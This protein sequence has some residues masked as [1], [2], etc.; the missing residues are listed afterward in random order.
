MKKH[1][2]T[3]LLL[4][5]C[6]SAYTQDLSFF[7]PKGDFSYDQNIPTPNQFFGHEIGAQHV[8]YD[9]AVAYMKLLAQK[10]DRIS[11]E[12]RGRTYQYRPIL[13]LYISSPDN[14]DNLENIRQDHLK[15]CDPA[16]SDK[17]D[18]QEMPIV[19]WLGYSIHGNEASGINA[20]LVVAYFLAAAQGQE[21]DRILRNSVIIMQPGT[22]PDGI[23]R[24]TTW[25]NNARSFT[26]VKDPNS[27]EFREPAPGS[28]GNHY[29]FD[30]NR[31]WVMVQQ[32]ESF[33]RSQ[34][35]YEWH[36]NLFSDFH[37]HGNIGMF[38]APGIPT[39]QN[40]AL[41]KDHYKMMDKIAQQY[42]TKYISGL[43]SLNYT[44]E[45]YDNWQP[46]C[47]DLMPSLLGSVSFLFEQTSSRGHIQER[48]GVT[49]R[50]ADAIRNQ[51]YGSYST[52][53]AGVDLKD[54]LLVYQRKAYEDARSDAAK[55][56]VK[57][58]VFGN[59]NNRSL[60]RE[61]YRI[62]KTNNIDVYQLNKDV[63]VEGKTFKSADSYIVPSEQKEYRMVKTIFEK[64]HTYVDSVFYD[65][66][67]WTV[68][69]SFS[70]NYAELNSA[71]GLMGKKVEEIAP[72][73]YETTP[74]ANFAYLFEIK[75]LYSYTFLYRLMAK[76]VKLR[77]GEIPFK[78]SINGTQRNFG[79]GT[80]MVPVGLQR[81][82]K[83]ELHRIVVEAA[84][85][86]P[87]EVVALDGSW[88][89]PIDLGSP[90]FKEISLPKIAIICGQG[91]STDVVGATWHLLDH[92]MKIPATLLESS[93]VASANVDLLQYNIIVVSGNVRFDK[94]AIDKL[95]AWAEY[96]KN[97]IIGVGQ[98]F[99]ILN[100]MEV[101]DINTL[102]R[103]E[104]VNNATYLDFSTKINVDP[105]ST[106][107]GV[108][109]ENYLDQS[110]PIA[111]GIGAGSV[112]TMKT[113]T[114]I[115]SK[116]K[117]KYMSP[118]YYK[119]NPL[120]S[121]CITA[122]NLEILSETPNVLASRNAIYFTDDPSFRAHWLGSARLLLNSF[123]FR[124]L[125]PA[126]KIE[127]VATP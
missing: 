77:A 8:T 16:A 97:T 75:D 58:Y 103:A 73:S 126:E 74:M 20:S 38:F 59:P 31:D 108:I 51:A 49:I 46:G 21:I 89:D 71:T 96:G 109:L 119:K 22:N 80:L 95:K 36:P 127:T 26:P 118:V 88:G 112:N 79:Y 15:L 28:R 116:P 114:N 54:E 78:V 98:A 94:T 91:T 40:P 53:N 68:P 105:N 122:K 30:L 6:L 107:G 85:D 76:E 13:F 2:L 10:S 81:V 27:R 24:F 67:T 39:N 55:A 63:T 62:L 86:V 48:N 34:I 52:I 123:F 25:V 42:H 47:G 83:E 110:H 35:I 60:D 106:I 90:R 125:M 11:T 1:L 115:L 93:L 14:L 101:A 104:N 17:L 61:F 117:G 69:L 44:K 33:Y 18:V 70:L 113:S 92:R 84:K 32:P 3:M 99:R 50:F 100:E 124:E 4:C 5:C 72:S 56:T 87:V 82:S 45:T 121:G 111:Y 19:T 9:L 7:L 12:E 64:K 102:K 23:Q 29:W 66:S 43:G 120:L 41:P 57:A 37:E 65:M